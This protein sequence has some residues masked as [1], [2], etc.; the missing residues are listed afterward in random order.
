[1]ISGLARKSPAAAMGAVPGC[2]REPQG[3]LGDSHLDSEEDWVL[4]ASIWG[5]ESPSGI[6]GLLT[7][8]W[9]SESL[10]GIVLPAHCFSV[11]ENTVTC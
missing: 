2:L 4:L 1:M 10:S 9:G 8:V 7:S 11:S 3:H 6:S 5:S